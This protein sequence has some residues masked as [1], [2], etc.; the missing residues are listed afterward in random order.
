MDVVVIG[1]GVVGLCVA[2]RLCLAGAAVTVVEANRVGAG[3]SEGNAGW[4]CPVLAAPIAGPGMVGQALRLSLRPS[5]SPLSIRPSLR[6]AFL[7]WAWRFA[8]ASRRAAFEHAMEAM[9]ALNQST[10][11]AF[12]RLRT[13]GVHFDEYNMGLLAGARSQNALDR[14][15]KSF[16]DVIDRGYAGKI[17]RCD[18]GELRELEPAFSD[19]VAGGLLFP[20]ERHVRPETLVHGLAVDL[21][22]RGA[23][24]E[25]GIAVTSIQ[26]RRQGWEIRTAE[27]SMYADRVVVAAG[28]ATP[29]L[30]APLGLPILIEAAR[31][32]SITASGTGTVPSH[33]LFMPEL[34]VG[35]SPFGETIRLVGTFELGAKTPDVNPKRVTRVLKAWSTYLRDWRPTERPVLWAG[36]RPSTPD[37]LPVVSSVPEHEGIF[38]ASGHGMLGVSLAPVTAELLAPLVLHGQQAPELE[39]LSIGRFRTQ[40]KHHG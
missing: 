28:V 34:K 32:Y 13:G 3:C 12:D 20:A 36:L 16:T 29:R 30:L 8:R 38:I 15:E 19:A 24:I 35:C 39:P 9:V 26:R 25:A 1:G 33:A 18:A 27:G 5:R 2:R 11:A 10:L 37:S 22:A 40:N 4:V 6:P 7:Q 23:R 21:R 14:L 31:G 17:E